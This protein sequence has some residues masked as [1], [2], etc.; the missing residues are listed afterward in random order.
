[1]TLA[2]NDIWLREP[3]LMVPRQAPLGP[4]RI[5]RSHP[6]GQKVIFGWLPTMPNYNFG[7][8][9]PV[10]LDTCTR[11]A[12]RYGIGATFSAGK[13]LTYDL[14]ELSGSTD[15]NPKTALYVVH[16]G[17]STW[18]W[19]SASG[20]GQLL[21]CGHGWSATKLEVGTG[22]TVIDS[23]VSGEFYIIGNN[24]AIYG[25]TSASYVNG[26]QTD[27][28]TN[29]DGRTG[30]I[31]LGRKSTADTEH[32]TGIVFAHFVVLGLMSYAEHASFALDPYQFLIPA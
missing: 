20:T 7:S 1:M 22:N 11:V 5:D 26:L 10:T 8:R 14:T 32:F 28:W 29:T 24:G 12:T 16:Y 17:T 2:Y 13:Y 23:P 9:F 27:T 15:A 21:S 3:R 25:Q 30:I 31:F 18:Q 4:V 6:I 19:L